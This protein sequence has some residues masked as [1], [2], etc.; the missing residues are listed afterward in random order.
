MKKLTTKLQNI[1]ASARDYFEGMLSGFAIMAPAILL[2]LSITVASCNKQADQQNFPDPTPIEQANTVTQYFSVTTDLEKTQ[3]DAKS[4]DI[5]TWQW[6]Y[7]A[8]PATLN[9]IGTGSSAGK[10]YTKSTTVEQ[11]R[12][13]TT[14]VN[15]LPGTYN[16]TYATIHD[17][18]TNIFSINGISTANLNYQPILSEHLDIKV[19][20]NEINITGSPIQ[21]T[22]T[23]EDY[24]L[25]VDIPNVSGVKFTNDDFS[26]NQCLLLYNSA[27]KYHWGYFTSVPVYGSPTKIKFT[28]GGVEKIVD[29]SGYQ[30]GIVY[31]LISAFDAVTQINIPSMSE[32]VVVVP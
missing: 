31:H 2:T 20:N 17:R 29:V 14:S 16:I 1:L 19:A 21:M 12:T 3:M 6:L 9:I 18:T 13:G 4:W 24:L 30:K 23:L 5:T 11:L 15:M 25:V 7:S 27:D 22:A 8:T 10:N 28:V 26:G 32:V